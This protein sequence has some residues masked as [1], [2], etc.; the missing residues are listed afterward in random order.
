MVWRILRG[1]AYYA[2]DPDAD[3][4]LHSITFPGLGSTETLSGAT[5]GRA[6][7]ACSRPA[8]RPLTPGIRWRSKVTCAKRVR[9]GGV[10]STCSRPMR[11]TLCAE[12]VV[13]ARLL[14]R[15]M[16]G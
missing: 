10:T 7:S 6:C 14:F 13:G 3:G 9:R 12:A 5:M 11:R 1:H 15:D 2:L 4:V 16:R 8:F